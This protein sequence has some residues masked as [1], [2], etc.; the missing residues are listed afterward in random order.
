FTGGKLQGRA[1]KRAEAIELSSTPVKV[2]PEQ[3]S[4]ALADGIRAEGLSL[5]TFSEKAQCLRER[6]N[7]LHAQLGEPWPNVESADPEY[8]LGPE[9]NAMA[10][11]TS[12]KNVDM[13]QALQRLMHWH[14]ANALD[15]LAPARLSGPS[16]SQPQI[17]LSSGR[18]VGRQMI[19]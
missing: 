6:L 7:F 5:F 13:H 16:G 2:S 17:D 18:V 10:H 8:W 11:G 19:S 15:E 4:A 3:A 14:E 1:I 9:L 12:P